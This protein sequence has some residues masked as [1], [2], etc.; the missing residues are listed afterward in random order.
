MWIFFIRNTVSGA[1]L[2]TFS[3]WQRLFQHLKQWSWILIVCT[4]CKTSYKV[5]SH[6]H[7]GL[8]QFVGGWGEVKKSESPDFRSPE[9]GISPYSQIHCIA[10]CICKLWMGF[11]VPSIIWVGAE[12][13][14][15]T[16]QRTHPAAKLRMTQDCSRLRN[17]VIMSG[18]FVEGRRQTLLYSCKNKKDQKILWRKL[19]D[20]YPKWG[21]DKQ[22]TLKH[23]NKQSGSN[24]PITSKHVFPKRSAK[25]IDGTEKPKIPLNFAK[26]TA[27]YNECGFKG[28]MA[29]P[30]W[31]AIHII[32]SCSI[33]MGSIEIE[34]PTIIDL[35]HN[36]CHLC[37]WSRIVGIKAMSCVNSGGGGGC[38]NKL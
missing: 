15:I 29:P 17:N 12:L 5:L 4:S 37:T 2:H 26:R 35:P 33:L 13:M 28:R 32:G 14:Q 24:A 6:S 3:H 16:M 22:V 25:M 18:F 10:L 20:S 7:W 36:T 21:D 11:S 31:P 27:Q 19:V 9:V 34:T 23:R 8:G 1:F 38:A 30:D